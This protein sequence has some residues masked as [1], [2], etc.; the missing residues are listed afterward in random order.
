MT[1]IVYL[2]CIYYVCTILLMEWLFDR[3]EIITDTKGSGN[4]HFYRFKIKEA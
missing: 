1:G 4:K 3:D 2:C